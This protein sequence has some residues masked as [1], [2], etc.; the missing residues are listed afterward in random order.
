MLTNHMANKVCTL[1]KR[2]GL[3]L[4]EMGAALCLSAATV[5]RIEHRLCG[6][7]VRT[8]WRYIDAAGQCGYKWTLEDFFPRSEYL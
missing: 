4:R 5:N 8:A 1:R 6:V 7:S 2:Q 3:S